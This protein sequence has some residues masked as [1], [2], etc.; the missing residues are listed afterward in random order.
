MEKK[1]DSRKNQMGRTSDS[2]TS[3]TS[4]GGFYVISKI[5]ILLEK[6][7]IIHE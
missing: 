6:K 1:R 7:T 3:R 2:T 5:N 4:G